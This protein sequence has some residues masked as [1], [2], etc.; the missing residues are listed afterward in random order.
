LRRCCRQSNM[1]EGCS[2]ADNATGSRCAANTPPVPA[3]NAQDELA[4]HSEGKSGAAGLSLA[5][6]PRHRTRVFKPHGQPPPASGRGHGIQVKRIPWMRREEHAHLLD[7]LRKPAARANGP[8][9]QN[10]EGVR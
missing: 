3:A 2:G 5:A 6:V 10:A 7:G 9:R 4:P 8:S 1:A